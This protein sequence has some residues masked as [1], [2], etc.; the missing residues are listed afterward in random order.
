[1]YIFFCR[2]I[3]TLPE[4]YLPDFADSKSAIKNHLSF[5]ETSINLE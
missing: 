3:D 5:K 1:M 2:V 4:L